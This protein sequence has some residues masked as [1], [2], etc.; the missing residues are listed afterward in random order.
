MIEMKDAKK[1]AKISLIE[2]EENRHLAI[3]TLRSHIRYSN[4]L[5]MF[6]IILQQHLAM[7]LWSFQIYQCYDDRVVMKFLWLFLSELLMKVRE[8]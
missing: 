8:D 1:H 7:I 5:T 3:N 6:Y 2:C 4:Y